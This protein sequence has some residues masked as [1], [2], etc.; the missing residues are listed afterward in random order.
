MYILSNILEDALLFVK[1]HFG[2]FLEDFLLNVLEI[3]LY[4][5]IL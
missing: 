2:Y 3:S 1:S 4:E 5:D